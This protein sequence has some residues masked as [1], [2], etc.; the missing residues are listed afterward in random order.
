VV[1]QAPSIGKFALVIEDESS[2]VPHFFEEG[3]FLIDDGVVAPVSQRSRDSFPAPQSVF[4]APQ[5]SDIGELLQ[6]F[7]EQGVDGDEIS[8]ELQHIAGIEPSGSSQTPPPVGFS[9]LDESQAE[10]PARDRDLRTGYHGIS[11]GVGLAGLAALSVIWFA[12][13]APLGATAPTLAASAPTQCVA[14][15]KVI[16]A[17][18]HAEIKIRSVVPKAKGGFTP[19]LAHGSEALFPR[20]P[21]GAP[22][23]VVVRDLDQHEASWSV[24]PVAPAELQ[25]QTALFPLEI[26]VRNQ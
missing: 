25:A 2:R 4:Y 26:S 14:S 12:V 1:A 10:P 8:R 21:C 19:L 24:I 22:L 7:N 16:D 17:P 15:I 9:E 5:K 23:E 18:A 6:R 11:F 3:A 20:L 13:R